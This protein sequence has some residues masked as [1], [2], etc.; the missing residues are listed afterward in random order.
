MKELP[1]GRG[2]LHLGI[3]PLQLELKHRYIWVQPWIW[4][5]TTLDLNLTSGAFRPVS[6][7]HN[8]AYCA[9]EVCP[10]RTTCAVQGGGFVA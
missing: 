6:R 10:V 2:H 4:N 7:V 1:D 8:E 5:L 9:R 3:T